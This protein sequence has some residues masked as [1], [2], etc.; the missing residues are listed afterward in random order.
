MQL[1][2][3]LDYEFEIV[4]A[5]LK[6]NQRQIQIMVDKIVKVAGPLKGKTLGVLGLTFKPNTDDIREAPAVAIIKK[7][8]DLGARIQT[9]DPAGM[10][11]ARK[12]FKKVEF[13]EDLY[14]ADRAPMPLI[15]DRMEP[16]PEH[17]LGA[18]EKFV[19]TSGGHRPAEY[20]RSGQDAQTGDNLLLCRPTYP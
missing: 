7:L 14:E 18:D 12:V 3:S 13:K 19:K 20:I 4:K 6:V 17:R 1:A 8:G 9:Y 15:H 10:P 11:E 5:V 2:Q 16:V